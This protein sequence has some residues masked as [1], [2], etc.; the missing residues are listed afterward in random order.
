MTEHHTPR[1][2]QRQMLHH[3]ALDFLFLVPASPPH[4]A[5]RRRHLATMD[6]AHLFQTFGCQPLVFFLRDAPAPRADVNCQDFL[7]SDQL[8]DVALGNLEIARDLRD[9]V[10]DAAALDRGQTSMFGHNHAPE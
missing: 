3:G 6:R 7:L 4:F 9:G 10:E 1:G 2:P 8:P 5:A